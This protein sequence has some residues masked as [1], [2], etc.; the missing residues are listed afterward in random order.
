MSFLI[1]N[2][3]TRRLAYAKAQNYHPR[4]PDEEALLQSFLPHDQRHVED[5]F[6][7][8]RRDEEHS[9]PE[10]FDRE[11][12]AM[13]EDNNLKKR[14]VAAIT[15]RRR[16]LAYWK[17]HDRKLQSEGDVDQ[18]ERAGTLFSGTQASGVVKPTT[19][20]LVETRSIVSSMAST[21]RDIDGNEALFPGPPKRASEHD[22]FVCSYCFV[23]CG[24]EDAKHSRWRW[25]NVHMALSPQ[26]QLC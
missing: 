8:L 9:G 13:L 14:C 4:D 11:P 3:S 18:P 7:D 25:V 12:N 26:L 21:V 1:R 20:D 2:Q 17:N 10:R 6:K 24:S 19:T 22:A 5:F 15:A 23:L 16:Q